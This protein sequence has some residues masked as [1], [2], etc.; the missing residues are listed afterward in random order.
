MGIAVIVFTLVPALDPV[1]A[2]DGHGELG[3]MMG[4]GGGYGYGRDAVETASHF[5]RHLLTHRRENGL[6][7]DQ[8]S[9]LKVIRLV[10]GRAQFGDE[11]E[12]EM[13]ELVLKGVLEDETSVLAVMQAKLDRSEC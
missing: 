11:A 5:L 9:K 3:M 6:T 12:I 7:D 2:D 13:E 4:R 1:W 8:V 10:R